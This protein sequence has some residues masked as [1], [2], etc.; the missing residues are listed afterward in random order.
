MVQRGKNLG[1]SLE[2]IEALR[3]SRE[4]VGEHL[5]SVVPFEHRV[6]PLVIS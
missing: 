6:T 5:Q 3:I 1:L 4:G 2:P